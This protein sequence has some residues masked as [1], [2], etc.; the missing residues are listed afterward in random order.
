MDNL[1]ELAPIAMMVFMMV[2]PL[3][4]AV[5]AIVYIV[6]LVRRTERRAEERLQLD[7]ENADI[8]IQQTKLIGE[9]DERMAG[10]EKVLREV[11]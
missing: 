9:L 4:V 5:A 6:R 8:Q 2:L 1:I 3:T 7:K 11:E 10:I